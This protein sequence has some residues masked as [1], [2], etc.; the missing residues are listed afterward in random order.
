MTYN[1][2][3]YSFFVVFSGTKFARGIKCNCQ[4][5]LQEMLKSGKQAD[6]T[7]PLLGHAFYSVILQIYE[8]TIF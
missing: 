5:I 7:V 4:E 2:I 1:L 6:L 3:K 8:Q